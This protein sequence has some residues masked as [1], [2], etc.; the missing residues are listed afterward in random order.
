[1]REIAEKI[2][3][4][5]LDNW[6]TD[7]EFNEVQHF[8]LKLIRSNVASVE[9]MRL[10]MET[11]CFHQ[12][13]LKKL[14]NEPEKVDALLKTLFSKAIAP[15]K[16]QKE[17]DNNE[18]QVTA[19]YCLEVSTDDLYKELLKEEHKENLK[20]ILKLIE[21][22]DE[23]I[24]DHAILVWDAIAQNEIN[25]QVPEDPLLITNSE[26]KTTGI[27]EFYSKELIQSLSAVLKSIGEDVDNLEKLNNDDDIHKYHAILLL[28]KILDLAKDDS[29]L[30]TSFPVLQTLRVLIPHFAKKN[31]SS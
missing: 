23:E 13:I 2:P 29:V 21:S 16:S 8:L 18:L 24:C 19:L 4:Y 30:T 20:A 10:G 3:V 15:S 6:L 12:S 7:K 11:L 14:K 25:E 22:E 17:E 1:M 5:E 26:E 9:D 27:I 28:S 31:L